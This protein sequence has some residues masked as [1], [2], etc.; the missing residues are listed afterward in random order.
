MTIQN[1]HCGKR[2]K[3]WLLCL[4]S[5][6]SF[7]EGSCLIQRFTVILKCHTALFHTKLM[8]KSAANEMQLPSAASVLV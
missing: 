5:L 2:K 6:S 8:W 1:Y 3:A 7:P 4:P